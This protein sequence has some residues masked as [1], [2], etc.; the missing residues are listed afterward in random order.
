MEALAR[1]TATARVRMLELTREYQAQREEFLAACDR[2]FSRGQLLGGDELR[3]LERELAE[4]VGVRHVRGVAS[5]TDALRLGMRAAGVRGGDEILVQANAFVA[6]VEAIV[7]VGAVPVAVDIDPSDLGPA[8]EA[9]AAAVGPRTRGILVVHMH[10]FPVALDPVLTLA[11]EHGL[12]VIEDCSHAHG[13]TFDARHV[14]SFGVLGAFSLGPIKNLG[15]FGDAGFV[16]TDDESLAVTVRLLGTHGQ[17]QK[18]EHAFYGWNSRLDELQAA[19]LRVK[20]HRLAARN[21]RRAE[22]AAYYT[23]RL[24]GR[25]LTPPTC[26]R[27]VHAWHQYVIRTPRRDALRRHLGQHDVETGVHYPVP[28]HRQPAWLAR[29]GRTPSMPHAERAAAEML[30]LPVHP[31]LSDA[32]V[33]RVAALVAQFLG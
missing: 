16:A 8:P 12:H 29:F 21:R 32:E 13:A 11:R 26:P 17:A 6:D 24:R 15:A 10:G 25:C 7:D 3:A 4:L 33:E 23:E 2:V 18:N 14:G 5:G 28:I 9:L 22:I 27:R 1:A 20:L 30:S 19:L 31:D